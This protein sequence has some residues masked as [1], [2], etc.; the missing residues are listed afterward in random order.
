LI[1]RLNRKLKEHDL[2]LGKTRSGSRAYLGD[3]FI[4]DS[5]LSTIGEKNLDA[6]DLQSMAMAKRVLAQWETLK[7]EG[8]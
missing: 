6:V 8:R 2:L 3:Y 4:M 1:Q 7:L 5:S